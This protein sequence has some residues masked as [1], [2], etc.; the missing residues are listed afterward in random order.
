MVWDGERPLLGPRTTGRKAYWQGWNVRERTC[1]TVTPNQINTRGLTHL[2]YA[3]I[4]FDP[5]TF[6]IAP[7]NTL[8]IPVAAFIK[9]LIAFMELYGFQGADLDWEYPAEPKRGGRSADTDNL[10]LLMKEAHAAFAG[11]FGLSLTIAPDYWYLRGF[12]PVEIEPYVDFMGFM[13]YDLHGPWDSDVKTL[14][15]KVRPQTDITEIERDLLPLW[16]DGVDPRKVV[17]GI[18]YYGRTYKLTDSS[19]GSMGCPFSGTGAPG[20]CTKTPGVLS[21]REIRQMIQENGYKPYTNTTA[22]V[23]Y[24]TYGGDNWVG[25]DDEDTYAMKELYADSRCLGGIMIWSIDFDATVGG[26]GGLNNCTSPESATVIPM[27]HTT[28]APK[29]TF[30]VTN[31][32][33][34]DINQLPPGTKQNYGLI[35]RYGSRQIPKFSASGHPSGAKHTTRPPGPMPPPPPAVTGPIPP[36]LIV[37]GTPKP[38][39]RP[40]P[41]PCCPPGLPEE[42]NEEEEDPEDPNPV[43]ILRPDDPETEDPDPGNPAPTP[44]APNEPDPAPT[45]TT[46]IAPLPPAPTA[47]NPNFSKDFVSCYDAGQ[48]VTSERLSGVVS[49]FCKVNFF[50]GYTLEYTNSI[51]SSSFSSGW[52][53]PNGAGVTTLV[54]LEIKPG[55]QWQITECN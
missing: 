17:M 55:C 21:N 37:N 9:S 49:S 36:I 1:D 31:P 25:Y 28:V 42:P 52:K 26:G 10:T 41:D 14:G 19:C 7:R 3:F 30:T 38:T 13:A 24:F 11:R 44:T 8:D 18:A 53:E 2:F 45:P 47:Q 39:T 46:S 20:R 51:M 16:F 54:S 32:I 43:C 12:K 23:K 15:P 29:A 35:P 6:Q 34:T 48:S 40:W 4:S 50:E 27:A 5:A 22:M 33:A